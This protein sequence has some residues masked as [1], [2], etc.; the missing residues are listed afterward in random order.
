MRSVNGLYDIAERGS[1]RIVDAAQPLGKRQTNGL[2][3]GW[4]QGEGGT[5]SPVSK[6]L[7]MLTP[8]M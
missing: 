5:E 1:G 2:S 7:V 6:R 4:S 8:S 3:H